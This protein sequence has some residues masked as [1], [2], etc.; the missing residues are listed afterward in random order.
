MIS[1][2]AGTTFHSFRMLLAWLRGELCTVSGVTFSRFAD[3]FP[4]MLA[5]LHLVTENSHLVTQDSGWLWHDCGTISLVPEQ[6][7]H[8]VGMTF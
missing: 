2:G 4:M 3:D 7:F 1:D 8:D 5:L 6:L